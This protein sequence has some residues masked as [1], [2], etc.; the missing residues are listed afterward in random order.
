M[1]GNPKTTHCECQSHLPCQEFGLDANRDEHRK[2]SPDCLFFALVDEHAAKRKAGTAKGRA[3][4]SSKASRLSTQSNVTTLSEAPVFMSV[5]D[6]PAEGDDSI[7][8]TAAAATTTSMTS[9]VRKTSAKGKPATKR[10]SKTTQVKKTVVTASSVV[11]DGSTVEAQVEAEE[12]VIQVLPKR[13]T[14]RD[15][16]LADTPKTNIVEKQS[17]PHKATR[18]RTTKAK[19]NLRVSDISRE[20]SQLQSELVAAVETSVHADEDV[21][22][23]QRGTKR[24]ITGAAKLNSSVILFDEV[25]HS[26]E[27]QPVKPKKGRKTKKAAE[28]EDVPEPRKSD[29]GQM[30]EPAPVQKPKA[31][32]VRK[33]K[34]A[35]EEA[36]PVLEPSQLETEEALETQVEVPVIAYM[37]SPL[38]PTAPVS[39]Q[40]QT[41]I[42]APTEPS[43]APSTP[44]PAK[45]APASAKI[46]PAAPSSSAPLPKETTPKRPSTPQSSDAE[47]QPPST[48]PPSSRPSLHQPPSS[49]RQTTHIP[50]ATSTP[51]HSPSK[52]ANLISGGLTST[53]PW[54]AADLETIFI[55]S[56]SSKRF[57]NTPNNIDFGDKENRELETLDLGTAP[58]DEVVRRVQAGLSSLE[59][60]M[61]VEEWVCFNATRGEERLRTECE[62]LVGVFETQ[63]GRA[64]LTLEGVE[65]AN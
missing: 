31:K 14:R 17:P 42:L 56:P 6:L 21:S 63:G 58:L 50:L 15:T 33:G 39:P 46:V 28:I 3:S 57:L 37:P 5:D 4:R 16:D 51:Q 59:K 8:T 22:G 41:P 55:P 7:L 61:S 47:N 35:A 12:I 54:T 29:L 65:C 24:D 40:Q 52:R 38:I 18:T 27:P 49:N 10:A 64:M 11:V 23:A 44:T 13:S 19:A 48:R 32:R 30:E 25:L 2:R 62:R 36:E 34:K 1:A 60:T 53:F 43:P 26:P 9:K 20:E 45:V